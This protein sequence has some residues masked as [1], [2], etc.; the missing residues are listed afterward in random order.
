M[1]PEAK[2][3]WLTALRSK[4]YLQGKNVLATKLSSNMYFCCLGV[5]C[6]ILP[7]VERTIEGNNLFT[8][9]YRAKDDPSNESVAT[10]LP[11][12]IAQKYGLPQANPEIF[13]AGTGGQIF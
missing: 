3:Q 9:G 11:E 1:D 10:V 6:E 4:Q 5:F 13:Y 12:F 7:E 2:A 8:I